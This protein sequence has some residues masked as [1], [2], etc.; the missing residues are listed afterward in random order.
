[1]ENLQYMY[2]IHLLEEVY[3]IQ[4]G[5]IRYIG[6]VETIRAEKQISLDELYR[7]VYRRWRLY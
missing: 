2:M 3:F 4:E 1:M 6:D 5:E 7:E